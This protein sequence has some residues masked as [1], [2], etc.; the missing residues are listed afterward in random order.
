M[1]AATFHPIQTVILK[2][3]WIERIWIERIVTTFHAVEQ[4]AHP[5]DLNRLIL[6]HSQNRNGDILATLACVKGERSGV[7]N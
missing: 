5:E 4:N 7:T 2:L 1:V 6:L 3:R